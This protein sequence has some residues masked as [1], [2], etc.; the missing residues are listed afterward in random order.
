MWKGRAVVVVVSLERGFQG[1]TFLCG[2][3]GI[4]GLRHHLQFQQ[5]REQDR[6]VAFAAT[7]TES[8][9]T[10]E[11]VVLFTTSDANL[12]LAADAALVHGVGHQHA[13][14][15]KLRAQ[16]TIVDGGELDV[17]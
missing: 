15:T 12:A 1:E 3:L 4:S 7:P 13:S 11:N 8:E 6:L 10:A 2:R 17:A 5:V 16:L 9:R 14:A